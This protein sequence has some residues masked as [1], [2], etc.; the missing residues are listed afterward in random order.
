MPKRI[1]R[2]RVKGWRM[3]ANTLY[4]GRGTQWGNPYP[5]KYWGLKESLRLY[6]E[7]INDSIKAKMVDLSELR[8]KNLACWCKLDKPCHADILLKLA[9]K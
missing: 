8:G 6:E 1:Q 9:N 3:P 2:K 5:V 4:V 7:Y